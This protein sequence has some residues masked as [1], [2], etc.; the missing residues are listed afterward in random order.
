MVQKKFETILEKKRE[1]VESNIALTQKVILNES[2]NDNI[3][4]SPLKSL[5]QIIK[6]RDTQAQTMLANFLEGLRNSIRYVQ[7]ESTEDQ[8]QILRVWA[9]KRWVEH[10]KE[11]MA[12]E[13]ALVELEGDLLWEVLEILTMARPDDTSLE[14]AEA[15]NDPV[16]Y[17][18][19]FSGALEEPTSPISGIAVIYSIIQRCINNDQLEMISGLYRLSLML[20]PLQRDLWMEYA[21]HA[22]T[23]ETPESAEAIYQ[24]ACE[25]FPGDFYV[26]ICMAEFY[27]ATARDVEATPLVISAL[28]ELTESHC[29]QTA[30]YQAFNELK[31]ELRVAV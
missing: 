12:E 18:E 16:K 8:Q 27:H 21:Q 13:E 1:E 31:G 10:M 9:A 26:R 19:D 17:T 5:E 30:T 24:Y 20:V 7:Q 28:K 14:E 6:E 15:E 23:F 22:W 3:K 4:P 11:P 25:L 29:E 2:L